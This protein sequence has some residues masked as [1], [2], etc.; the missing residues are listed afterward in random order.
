[1][2]SGVDKLSSA[3]HDGI[4]KLQSAA[5]S[6]FREVLELHRAYSQQSGKVGASFSAGGGATIILDI[7]DPSTQVVTL[8]TD[9]SYSLS[10]QCDGS[11]P[12]NRAHASGNA[13]V[14]IAATTFFGARH[15]LE[16]LSQLLNWDD[17][18]GTYTIACGV[19]IA[20]DA[21]QFPYRGVMMD[22]SRSFFPVVDIRRTIRA[23]VSRQHLTVLLCTC[24]Y[25]YIR[26]P[27][28]FLCSSSM[29]CLGL[30]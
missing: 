5:D 19:E 27:E 25:V 24:M 7:T 29:L 20:N 3:Q 30:Q 6:H 16:T 2:C 14:K 9:E 18:L 8:S 1:M 22:L 10:I 12:G 11:M 17:Y 26:L 4:N 23:M 15:A 13:V 28:L 21:P